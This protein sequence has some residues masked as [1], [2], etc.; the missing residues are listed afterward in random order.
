MFKDEG[1]LPQHACGQMVFKNAREFSVLASVNKVI[2]DVNRSHVVYL[3]SKF[4][5]VG[6]PASF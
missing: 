6:I 4:L 2:K 5:E 1:Y 3:R